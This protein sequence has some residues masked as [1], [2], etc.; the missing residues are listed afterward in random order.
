MSEKCLV[1][2][3]GSSSL[4]FRLYE[5]PSE[6]LIANGLIEK[7]GLGVAS[8]K[9][10]A[11]ADKFVGNLRINNHAEAFKLMKEKLGRDDIN[12]IICHIGSRA[13][14]TAVRDGKSFD[15]TIG[16][17]TNP[18]P[19]MCTRSRNLE[20][21]ILE[22]VASQKN[23]SIESVMDDLSKRSDLIGVSEVSSDS[24]YVEGASKMRND[25]AT[26]ALKLL[27]K[28]AV[29]Y[30]VTYYNELDGNVD[31]IIFTA[32]VGENSIS[33]REA[34]LNQYSKTMPIILDKNANQEIAGF[35]ERKEGMI[36]TEKSDIP[37]FVIPTNE[38]IMIARE[39][40]NLTNDKVYKK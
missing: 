2:N 33:Y 1:I 40:Y 34:V 25:K 22:D 15:T 21:A 29:N 37:V 17:G 13:S 7:I 19:M 6:V 38:E 3:A 23:A 4:K 24:R 31:A 20:P 27:I 14:I 9:V 35:K 26:L 5:M 11:D 16:L 12:L 18:G 36:T 32:G 39:V 30:I 28:S 8:C 10:V